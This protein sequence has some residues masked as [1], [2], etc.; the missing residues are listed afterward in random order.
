VL[1]ELEISLGNASGS[2]VCLRVGRMVK[3]QLVVFGTFRTLEGKTRV[4]WRLVEVET[5][6]I[7]EDRDAV[8]DPAGLP[9]MATAMARVIK[10]AAGRSE[11]KGLARVAVFP[12]RNSS[13]FVR[14][15][16][17]ERELAEACRTS[18]TRDGRFRVLE[19]E[20]SEKLL[21]E[22]QLGRGGLAR[23]EPGPEGSALAADLAIRG[24]FTEKRLR[25]DTGEWDLEVSVEL[26]SLK[27]A[28]RVWEARFESRASEIR[29][30]L[31]PLILAGLSSTGSRPPPPSAEG[32]RT[33]IQQLLEQG[34]ALQPP[35]PPQFGAALMFA[36]DPRWFQKTQKAVDCFESALFLDPDSVEARRL[37]G[38][39][40]CSQYKQ[41]LV[42]SSLSPREEAKRIGAMLQG[43]EILESLFKARLSE[44][45]TDD[46]GY[47]VDCLTRSRP[48]SAGYPLHDDYETTLKRCVQLAFDHLDR[49]A[50]PLQEKIANAHAW[51][52]QAEEGGNAE[53]RRLSQAELENVSKG[54]KAAEPN[55]AFYVFQRLMSHW[56]RTG[57][58]PTDPIAK[59]FAE[60]SESP[61]PL[62]RYM[63][64]LYLGKYYYYH[65]P[66]ADRYA[67][68]IEHL[69]AADAVYREHYASRPAAELEGT[70]WEMLEEALLFE[71]RSYM[72]LRDWGKAIGVLKPYVEDSLGKRKWPH[73]SIA[74]GVALLG[75]SYERAERYG[76]AFAYYE[77]LLGLKDPAI[78]ASAKVE[79]D[80]GAARMRDK[81]GRHDVAFRSQRVADFSNAQVILPVGDERWILGSVYPL[82]DYLC[83]SQL[84]AQIGRFRVAGAIWERIAVPEGIVSKRPSALCRTGQ[85]VWVG[86][87]GDG[88]F[89]YD[90]QTAETVHFG[91]D[92]GLLSG[93]IL[94]LAASPTHLY[95]GVSS[96]GMSEAGGILRYDL[97]ENRLGILCDTGSEGIPEYPPLSLALSPDNKQLWVGLS[98]FAGDILRR[99]FLE[100]NRWES[101]VHDPDAF[102][103]QLQRCGTSIYACTGSKVGRYDFE[104]SA[105]HAFRTGKSTDQKLFNLHGNNYVMRFEVHDGCV[106]SF[107]DHT[108]YGYDV[109]SGEPRA[110]PNLSGLE[111]KRI[112]LVQWIDGEF[113]AGTTEAVFR[114]IPQE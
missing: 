62:L 112:T 4:Q 15:D 110:Y 106:W 45:V 80:N 94:S 39:A 37:L 61:N 114:L 78:D 50:K 82:S 90:P 17:L 96:Q 2:E 88:L 26:R 52:V 7:R 44:A 55:R 92:S 58:K 68:A 69:Q 28:T 83:N 31:G 108:L 101:L 73:A 67:K 34:K 27:D 42:D 93:Y 100:E 16:D 74:N 75:E 84:A 64:H 1:H 72:A 22:I 47:A 32:K 57:A 29:L 8:P 105:W 95:I 41:W 6:V 14:H 113:F 46:F 109:Q 24:S 23:P 21:S 43:A 99:F 79:W 49:F 98:K 103:Y 70:S 13:V 18:A 60:S 107:F 19:R 89:R 53:V 86:T 51:I 65:H 85:T 97:A 66:E 5:G 102:I 11:R 71:A 9:G 48:T 77:W 54:N 35:M 104:P 3:A 12:F 91:T 63:A 33:E 10:E 59:Y 111:A 56:E 36:Q 81:L 76:D 20:A 40:L 38:R 30:K 87:F 25:D